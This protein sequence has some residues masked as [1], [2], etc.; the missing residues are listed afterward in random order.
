ML[1]KEIMNTSLLQE[2]GRPA[3]RRGWSVESHVRGIAGTLVLMSI[4]LAV[5]V[6]LRWL[7]LAAFVGANLLQSSLSGWCLMSNLL[8]LFGIGREGRSERV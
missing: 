4:A 6:D 5:W 3:E 1:R 2:L 7:W 8:A